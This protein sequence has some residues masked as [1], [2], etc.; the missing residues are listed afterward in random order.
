MSHIDIPL[1]VLRVEDKINRI[2]KK[3][4]LI[5]DKQLDTLNR[6]SSSFRDCGSNTTH[7]EKGI[8]IV[9]TFSPIVCP[10]ASSP[11]PARP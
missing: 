6:S 1:K 3:T 9:T 5:L 4:Y 10:F 8:S 7:Y 2:E 11:R